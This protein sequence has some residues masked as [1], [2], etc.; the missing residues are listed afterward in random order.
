ME[1]NL[2]SVIIPIY[3]VEKYLRQCIDSVLNQTYKNLEVILVDDGS[4]DSCPIICDEYAEQDSR[5]KVIHKKN[6]GLSDARNSGIRL[7]TGDYVLFIDSDDFYDDE[8]A[9]EKLI[10]RVCESK[11]QI[12]NFSYKKYYEGSEKKTPYFDNIPAMPLNLTQKE[13]QLEYIVGQNLFI[14][15]AWNKMIDKCLLKDAEF[16]VGVY[17]EDIDWC[18]RI[19]L[20]SKKIDFIPEELYCYR[21]REGSISHDIKYKSCFDLSNNIKKCIDICNEADFETKKYLYQYTAFQYTTFIALQAYMKETPKDLIS[22][23]ANYKWL[24]RYYGKNKK[25]KMIYLLC[26]FIGFK[27]LC[28]LVKITKKIWAKGIL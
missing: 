5:V 8:H 23:M 6:G 13:G 11:A 12:L 3:N 16:E 2:V 25:V 17:S 7:L 24:L 21:Q 15:S 28:R 10:K 18:A 9:I 26:K 19:L 4:T 20:K 27:N 14:A 22:E 1:N